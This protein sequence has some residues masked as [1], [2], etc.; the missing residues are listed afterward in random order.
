MF[1]HATWEPF[2][3]SILKH[4]LGGAVPFRNYSDSE[5][6][7]VYLSTCPSFAESMVEAAD[8]GYEMFGEDVE[9]IILEVDVD[10][11]QLSLDPNLHD[12]DGISLVYEGI[13]PTNRLTLY[14]E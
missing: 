6:R 10:P 2:V 13:I 5:S 3:P 1:Y 7:Y 8:I 9:I 14:E 12:N 4:G 11:N